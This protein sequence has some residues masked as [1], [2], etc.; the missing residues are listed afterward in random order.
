MADEKAEYRE[1]D[2]P[3]PTMTALPPTVSGEEKAEAAPKGKPADKV[4]TAVLI[5]RLPNGRVEAAT[6][7]PGIEVDHEASLLDIRDMCSALHEDVT[8]SIMAQSVAGMVTHSMA[9]A[10]QAAQ[11][12]Q[13][14]SQIQGKR[15]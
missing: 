6:R 11:V 3:D 5:V 4:S 2:D 10:V 13:M 9:K 14:Q 7:I 12:R 15:R 8:T 1:G